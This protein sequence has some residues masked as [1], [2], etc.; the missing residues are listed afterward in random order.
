MAD[1]Y[2][3]TNSFLKSQS[4]QALTQAINTRNM[5][6]NQTPGAIKERRLRFDMVKPALGGAPKL[7]DVFGVGDSTTPEILRLNAESDEWLAKYFPAISGDLKTLPEDML[8]GIIAGTKPYG[9]DRTALEI[10]WHQARDRTYR[11]TDAEVRAIEQRFAGSG[12]S[13]PQGAMVA[14]I[15][16]A[17]QR[18]GQAI[19]EVNWQQAIKDADIRVDLLKFAEEQAVRLKMGALQQMGEFY[20]MWYAVPDRDIERARVRAQALGTFYSAMGNYHNVEL[21]F[22]AMRLDIEK[23]KMDVGLTY[24]QNKVALAN[25]NNTSGALGQATNALAQIAAANGAAASTLVAKV[26]DI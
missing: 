1:P 16:A 5:I 6:W 18:A 11:A 10:V 15:I 12:F 21:A 26:E 24:D 9:L 22:E 4:S 23:T 7:S 17:E 14:A 13:M 19:A 2:E 25:G 3:D 20:R 8:V